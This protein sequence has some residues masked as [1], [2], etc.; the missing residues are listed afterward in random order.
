M[1]KEKKPKPPK[2]PPFWVDVMVPLT[3]EELTQEYGKKCRV[4]QRGCCCCDAYREWEKTG[5]ASLTVERTRL[6]APVRW[7]Y[8]PEEAAR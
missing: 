8:E 7:P 5:S 1:S 2:P 4:Y 3:K 6:L